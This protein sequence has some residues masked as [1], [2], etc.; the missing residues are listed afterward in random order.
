M[1]HSR[2]CHDQRDICSTSP[3]GGR[4]ICV[5]TPMKLLIFTACERVLQDPQ[6]GQSLI[7]V[8]HGLK[9]QIPAGTEL[10]SNAALPKF[11]SIFTK[12]GLSPHEEG[13]DYASLTQIYWPDG[14][15]FVEQSLAAAQPTKDGLNFVL[16]LTGFPMGQSGNLKIVNWVTSG[17]STVTEKQEIILTLEVTKDLSSRVRC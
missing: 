1:D 10:P 4:L 6:S 5:V 16:Q 9:F 7:A 12:W 8:F 15:L 14:T 13:K 2:N 3:C 11:W 17:G